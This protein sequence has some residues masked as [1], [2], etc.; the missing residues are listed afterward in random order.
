MHFLEHMASYWSHGAMG[1]PKFSDTDVNELLHMG[2][3]ISRRNL[4]EAK[5]WFSRSISGESV[6]PSWQPFEENNCCPWKLF[7]GGSLFEMIYRC[8][9]SLFF[10]S[11]L[12]RTGEISRIQ[13]SPFCRGRKRLRDSLQDQSSLRKLFYDLTSRPKVENYPNIMGISTKWFLGV[14]HLISGVWHGSC[15]RGKQDD[16]Q[17]T[18]HPCDDK[19]LGV[20]LSWMGFCMNIRRQTPWMFEMVCFWEFL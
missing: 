16:T 17:P 3:L 10:Q 13:T 1:D 15:R 9:W 4:P 12:S 6:L 7:F 19:Q 20:S 5:A 11:W 14:W 18:L 8:L 2:S